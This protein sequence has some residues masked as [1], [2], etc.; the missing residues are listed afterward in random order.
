MITYN[1]HTFQYLHA[2]RLVP[3]SPIQAY[4]SDQNKDRLIVQS[5]LCKQVDTEVDKNKVLRQLREDLEDVFGGSFCTKRHVVI[6][7]MLE[8]D[9]REQ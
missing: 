4:R 9:T 1:R 3:Q 8:C 7:V 6:G 2:Y 5:C